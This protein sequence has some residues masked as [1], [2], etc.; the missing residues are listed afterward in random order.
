MPR[1]RPKGSKNLSAYERIKVKKVRESLAKNGI[2]DFDNLRDA[3]ILH[4]IY[5]NTDGDVFVKYENSRH[6]IAATSERKNPKGKRLL[7]K[8]EKIL[9]ALREAL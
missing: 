5:V 4:S 9:S 6:L 3:Q 8:I 1:G 2:S 7:N